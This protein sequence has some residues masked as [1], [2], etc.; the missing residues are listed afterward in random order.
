MISISEVL[1]VGSH[2]TMV[3]PWAFLRSNQEST[4]S[5]VRRGYSSPLLKPRSLD[6]DLAQEV[7]AVHEP[8]WLVAEIGVGGKEFLPSCLEGLPAL[9]LGQDVNSKARTGVVNIEFD[10]FEFPVFLKL[11]AQ[12]VLSAI[13][14]FIVIPGPISKS[15]IYR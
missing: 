7:V 8:H 15:S 10:A 1:V 2:G 5:R 12:P 3:A 9:W 6:R 13:A 14:L 11:L 4:E